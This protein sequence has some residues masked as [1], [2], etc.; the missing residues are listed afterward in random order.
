MENV[1]I[2]INDKKLSVPAGITILEAATRNGI[3]IPTLCHL[4]DIDPRASCRM[5][6][7]EVEKA[8]TFQPSCAT[9]VT[10]GMVIHTD[11]DR[12]RH[13]RKLTL[14]LILSRHAVDCHH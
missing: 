6:I 1:N 11:T 10:E 4:K 12:L 9:K 13:Q 7:V 8:R 3:R 2:T 14:Q 5:C